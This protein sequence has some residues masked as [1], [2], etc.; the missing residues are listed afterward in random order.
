MWVG[1]GVKLYHTPVN[2]I[3]RIWHATAPETHNS[4]QLNWCTSSFELVRDFSRLGTE[5]RCER[6]IGTRLPEHV[7]SIFSNLILRRSL[8]HCNSCRRPSKYAGSLAPS[9]T[10]F[11]DCT[12]NVY[13]I[14]R[15]GAKYRDLIWAQIP[16]IDSFSTQKANL[17]VFCLVRQRYW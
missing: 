7:D 3:S 8:T 5:H 14:A 13:S 17:L 2:R 6:Q 15:A 10:L 11:A 16:F 12:G 4:F 9:E 1:K